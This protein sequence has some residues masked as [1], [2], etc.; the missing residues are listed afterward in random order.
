MLGL[1]PLTNLFRNQRFTIRR[2]WEVFFSDL[3]YLE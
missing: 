3:E 2:D 1:A